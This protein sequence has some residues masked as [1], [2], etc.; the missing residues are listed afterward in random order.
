MKP[1]NILNCEGVLK[2]ADFGWSIRDKKE[3]ETLCGTIDYLPPEMV[4]G[5]QY[6]NSVDLWSLGILTYEMTTGLTPF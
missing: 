6:D 1:E 2:I 4:Y 3:R 5:Q